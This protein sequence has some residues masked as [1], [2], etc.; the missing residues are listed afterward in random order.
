MSS[1]EEGVRP[2]S[3]GRFA[4]ASRR[5]G[6][7]SHGLRHTGGGRPHW[8]E[9]VIGVSLVGASL[10]MVF[11]FVW[12]LLSAFKPASV[13]TSQNPGFLPLNPTLGNFTQLFGR[14]PFGLYLAN[15][16]GVAVAT[17]AVILFTSS[18]MGFVLSV[19]RIRGATVI[20]VILLSSIAVPF[21]VKVIPLYSVMVDFHLQ[22]S[23]AALVLPFAIDAFGIYLFREFMVG[24]PDEYVD[25]ARLDGASEWQIYWRVVMPMCKPIS[26]TLGIF[27][28]VY[29]WDQLLWPTIVIASDRLRTLPLGIALLSSEQGAQYGLS[30]AAGLLATVPPLLAFFVLQGRIQGGV[31]L[32]GMK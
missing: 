19:T 4:T 1:T 12:M 26:A 16:V 24:I 18:M 8:A 20:F 7:G 13:L 31:M 15:S 23:Y 17:V 30:I 27:A 21:E 32:A 10:V 6:F 22:D 5:L 11:P 29:A 28:F 2:S 25:A 3:G 14:F 9:I